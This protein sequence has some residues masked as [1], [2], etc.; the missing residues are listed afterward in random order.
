MHT[1][2]DKPNLKPIDGISEIGDKRSV[3]SELLEDFLR[4]KANMKS[5]AL[6]AGLIALQLQESQD[7][8]TIRTRHTSDISEFALNQIM[9][10]AA[11]HIDRR[12]RSRVENARFGLLYSYRECFD[13]LDAAEGF[14]PTLEKTSR[15]TNA[16]PH[17]DDVEAARKLAV[18]L[19]ATVRLNAEMAKARYEK[20]VLRL[21]KRLAEEADVLEKQRAE[22]KSRVESLSKALFEVSDELTNSFKLQRHYAELF[23]A[24]KKRTTARQPPTDLDEIE[25][26]IARKRNYLDRFLKPEIK[27]ASEKLDRSTKLR[28]KASRDLADVKRQLAEARDEL[29][30]T[31]KMSEP[32]GV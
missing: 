4:H 15:V 8:P 23:E 11:V 7:W 13:I 25:K 9:L 6:A 10:S 5:S 28:E 16:V 21:E 17:Q 1:E 18:E 2:T 27:S 26:D 3:S 29:A 19:L 20:D 22:H 30:I 32:R 24:E 31:A 12:S 14:D